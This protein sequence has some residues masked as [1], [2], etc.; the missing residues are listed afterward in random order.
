[1]QAC[2]KSARNH[3][4]PHYCHRE[5]DDQGRPKC[6]GQSISHGA[7]LSKSGSVFQL[8]GASD[9]PA[10][11]PASGNGA[12]GL[13]HPGP[14]SCTAGHNAGR[15]RPSRR[16]SNEPSQTCAPL[17]CSFTA[18]L[19]IR[20]SKP[21]DNQPSILGFSNTTMRYAHLAPQHQA[22]AV[23]RLVRSTST[24]TST[25]TRG[26]GTSESAD[27]A[28][29]FCLWCGGPESNRHGPCSPRDFKS[30]ASTSSATPARF[31]QPN[32]NATDAR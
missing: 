6:L 4:S 5:C 29:C 23:E 2:S 19:A 16:S 30:L 22:D 13:I 10:E 24:A 8:F 28:K 17:R 27:A 1:M 3:E 7:R 32:D 18:R 21:Q 9:E 25:N 31:L 26:A 12:A 14:P 20:V 11:P 15:R